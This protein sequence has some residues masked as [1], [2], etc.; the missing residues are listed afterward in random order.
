MT[1]YTIR[2][3]YDETLMEADFGQASDTIYYRCEDG[4]LTPSPYQVADAQH[5]PHRAAE[6]LYDF[7]RGNGADVAG[8][9]VISVDE[10]GD[11][12]E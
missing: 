2:T 7:F 10:I 12:A 1:K 5:S 8:A 3:K 6:L 9:D 4:E 11:D